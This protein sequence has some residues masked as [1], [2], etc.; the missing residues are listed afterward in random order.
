MDIIQELEDITNLSK[1]LFDAMM[2]ANANGENSNNNI[3][4][5]YIITTRLQNLQTKIM[6]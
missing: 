2:F 4:L 6:K 1:T 5:A 3:T